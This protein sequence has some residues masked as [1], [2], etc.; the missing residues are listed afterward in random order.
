MEFMNSLI[1]VNNTDCVWE[2][3]L[4]FL[5]CNI[6]EKCG[7]CTRCKPK[8]GDLRMKAKIR[9]W[10]QRT[11]LGITVYALSWCCSR[12]ALDYDVLRELLGRKEQD[13][14]QGTSFFLDF[15]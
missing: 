9:Y 1:H 8:D 3:M 13:L 15:I 2:Q 10:E 7:K 4:D 5:N 11:L 12:F 14:A 6:D